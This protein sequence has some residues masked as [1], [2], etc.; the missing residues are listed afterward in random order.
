MTSLFKKDPVRPR[1]CWFFVITQVEGTYEFNLGYKYADG[2]VSFFSTARRGAVIKPPWDSPTSCQL[3]IHK[4]D[5][6]ED[7]EYFRFLIKSGEN[8]NFKASQLNNLFAGE[9]AFARK[10]TSMVIE[11]KHELLANYMTLLPS[12]AGYSHHRSAIHSDNGVRVDMTGVTEQDLVD[13]KGSLKDFLEFKALAE[14]SA[15]V[16]SETKFEAIAQISEK[17]GSKKRKNQHAENKVKKISK[18][19]ASA[20]VLEAEIKDADGVE[21]A[22]VN[23]YVGRADV[24]IENLSVSAKLCPRL[25]RWKV[26]GIANA[27]KLRFD[28]SKIQMTVAP[29][30]PDNFDRSNLANN[31]YVVVSGNHSLAALQ[32]LDAKGEMRELVSL[33]DGAIPCYIVNTQSPTVL[34]YG[35][36]RSNDLA[37]KFVRPP[38][39]EDLLFVYDNLK[40][41]LVKA[42]EAFEA[43]TRY[44]KLLSMG[45]DAI[46]AIKKLCFWRQDSFDSLLSVIGLYEK[47]ETTD[48]KYE[49]NTSRLL[50]GETLPIPKN[51][52]LKLAKVDMTFFDENVAGIMTKEFSLKDL[53]ENYRRFQE[54]LKTVKV[55][56]LL[57]K[58]Q[59]IENLRLQFPGKFGDNIIEQLQEQ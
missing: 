5:K 50:K 29:E 35:N 18:S 12:S 6:G 21:K 37:S 28:P 31:K 3:R 42:G 56:C 38:R 7:V 22:Y 10:C 34:C 9:N 59:S 19:Q 27:M 17:N 8:Q 13:N 55:I 44:A 36:I 46:T 57:S 14:A 51:L 53:V 16:I 48:A 39:C 54:N 24:K 58:Y 23:S 25:N 33:S 20:N 49:G 41:L 32:K 2:T 52:F 11:K 1:N 47:Y 45:A 30:D 15:I 4:N 26:D 40:K 43:V